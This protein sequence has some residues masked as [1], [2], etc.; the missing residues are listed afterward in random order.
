MLKSLG[1]HFVDALP[2][3][4]FDGAGA[5]GQFYLGVAFLQG[6]GGFDVVGVGCLAR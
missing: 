5:V 4:R 2:L 1:Q 6:K 3:Q